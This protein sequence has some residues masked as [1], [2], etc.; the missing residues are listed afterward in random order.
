MYSWNTQADTFAFS[1]YQYGYTVS[2]ITI[3]LCNN[4][5]DRVTHEEVIASLVRQGVSPPQAS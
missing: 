1:A 2:R 5:Y 4:G 3:Q